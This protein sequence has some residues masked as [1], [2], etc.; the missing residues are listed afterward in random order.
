MEKDEETEEISEDEEIEINEIDSEEEVEEGIEEI[1]EEVPLPLHL[2]DQARVSLEDT[3]FQS[4]EALTSID[5]GMVSISKDDEEEK[6]VVSY[7]TSGENPQV[8][9]YET[10]GRDETLY[11]PADISITDTLDKDKDLSR[12]D[13][14]EEV[15]YIDFKDSQTMGDQ[16]YVKEKYKV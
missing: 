7:E 4:N 14:S 15:N 13:R 3:F 12:R 10:G 2:G 1:I 5:Q 8:M 11:K 6:Q 16:K 9:K